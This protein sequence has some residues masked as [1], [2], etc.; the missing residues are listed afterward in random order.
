M[1]KKFK[2][3]MLLPLGVTSLLGAVRNEVSTMVSAAD[4]NYDYV[5]SSSEEFQTMMT[6][7]LGSTGTGTF[8]KNIKL[9]A[10]VEYTPVGFSN[11]AAQQV[12]FTGIFEGNNKK[13]TYTGTSAE[14]TGATG[15]MSLFF[16]VSGTVRNLTTAGE[17]YGHNRVAPICVQLSEGGLIDNCTN[18]TNITGVDHTNRGEYFGG[19]V[20][21]LNSSNAP[22][23]FATISNC[24]NYGTITSYSVS[25][26][27]TDGANPKAYDASVGGIAGFTYPKSKILNCVNEGDIITYGSRSAGIVGRASANASDDT[28]PMIIDNCVNNGNVTFKESTAEGTYTSTQA[29]IAGITSTAQPQVTVSNCV[30]NG[31]VTSETDEYVG[32]IVSYSHGL[33]TITDCVNTGAVVSKGTLYAG[34][35]CSYSASGSLI[36]NCINTADVTSTG[37]SCGGIAGYAITSTIK[38]CVNEGKIYTSA[39]TKSYIGGIVGTAYPYANKVITIENCYNGGEVNASRYN[40]AILGHIEGA[41]TTTAKVV[42]NNCL[43]GG[44]VVGTSTASTG[45]FVG[46]IC[47]NGKT[48]SNFELNNC[49]TINT[50]TYKKENKVEEFMG[51]VAVTPSASTIYAAAEGVSENVLTYIEAVRKHN[52]ENTEATQ[53]TLLA[54]Q[55]SAEEQT[56]LSTLLCYAEGYDGN[57][58]Y[59][60]YIED[61]NYILSLHTNTQLGLILDQNIINQ[62]PIYTVVIVCGICLVTYLVFIKKRN[63]KQN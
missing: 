20:A 14:E 29:L 42:F 15:R 35:I 10:D 53:Q 11:S 39:T 46:K 22:T 27:Q 5:I 7:Y 63:T 1:N 25:K 56:L 44:N 26:T 28:Y 19:F 24:K 2:L 3:L 34:G 38:N 33:S 55:L 12:K 43:A 40:G 4:V 31:V 32:G 45:G 59:H 23:D 30:N 37:Q 60:S 18:Y 21:I 47:G 54:T 49:V 6:D 51:S 57:V 62:L 36:E 17:I 61:A 41:T 58:N 52:C 13:I 50:Y 48:T 9:E 16:S 8:D